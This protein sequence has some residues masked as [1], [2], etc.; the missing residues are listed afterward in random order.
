MTVFFATMT[1]LYFNLFYVLFYILFYILFCKHDRFFYIL[2]DKML[3]G[4]RGEPSAKGRWKAT[5]RR[6]R[7]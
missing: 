6:P 4:G 7:G 3:I 5:L 1:V 2:F